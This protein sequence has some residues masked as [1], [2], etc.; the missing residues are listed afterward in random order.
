MMFSSKTCDSLEEAGKRPSA[1]RRLWLIRPG[2]GFDSFSKLLPQ[3]TQVREIHLG[4]QS[5]A[6]L[7]EALSQL[8]VLRS[9]TVLN[10]PIRR[11]PS[12]LASC[13]RLSEL[14]L[15]GTNITS[16]P[17]SVQAFRHLRHLDFSNHPVREI[18][19][20]LGQWSKLRD[21]Q[22]ADLGLK[23]LPGSIAGLR[24]VR[25]LALAGNRFSAREAARI[26]GWFR[27]GVVSGCGGV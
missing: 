6:G 24:H 18:P 11:F 20:E 23:S 12:F 13:P 3:L 17:R 21:I 26:R 9:L 14:V 16:I 15:R 10:T 5:W 7:P 1:V 19:P 25:S 4:W 8:P 2:V 27:P 22:L